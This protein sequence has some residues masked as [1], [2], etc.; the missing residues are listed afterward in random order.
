MKI[1]ESPPSS[2]ETSKLCS[3]SSHSL[4]VVV[5]PTHCS[6]LYHKN[7]ENLLQGVWP[8]QNWSCWTSPLLLLALVSLLYF[9]KNSVKLQF[10]AQGV[11]CLCQ[12]WGPSGKVV[13]VRK[14]GCCKD[15]SAAFHTASFCTSEWYLF[16][17]KTMLQEELYIFSTFYFYR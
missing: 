12:F 8:T 16:L 9:V 3:S 1:E 11:C 2:A 14:P 15:H 6:Y 7:S 10:C 4:S 5:F 17:W 13:E